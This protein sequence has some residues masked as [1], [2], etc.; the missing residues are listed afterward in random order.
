MIGL[1][2]M[3]AGQPSVDGVNGSTPLIHGSTL[4][5]PMTTAFTLLATRDSMPTRKDWCCKTIISKSRLRTAHET[6]EKQQLPRRSSQ[7]IIRSSCKFNG[8]RFPEVNCIIA[9]RFLNLL[10]LKN[11]T[12]CF[13]DKIPILRFIRVASSFRSKNM[14]S[15]KFPA[16]KKPSINT[17]IPLIPTTLMLPP[18][19]ETF[20]LAKLITRIKEDHLWRLWQLFIHRLQDGKPQI[21]HLCVGPLGPTPEV[22][23]CCCLDSGGGVLLKLPHWHWKT[24]GSWKLCFFWNWLCWCNMFINSSLFIHASQTF[25]LLFL[26]VQLTPK[27][28]F[29]SHHSHPIWNLKISTW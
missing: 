8:G 29:R 15:H 2:R 11:A 3:K 14:L 18:S 25:Q 1:M 23:Y 10:I 5:W 21:Q 16:N 4:R 26:A 12:C 7:G 13:Y 22:S 20:D 24:T 27:S 19:N 9:W 28:H 17:H 6:C